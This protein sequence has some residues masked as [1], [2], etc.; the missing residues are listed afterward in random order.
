MFRY[1]SIAI[2]YWQDPY[3]FVPLTSVPSAHWKPAQTG[4]DSHRLS[5]NWNQSAPTEIKLPKL[6]SNCPNWYQTAQTEIRLP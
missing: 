3:R 2:G 1:V 6:K 4:T 5:P